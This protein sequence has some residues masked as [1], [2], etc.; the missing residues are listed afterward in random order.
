MTTIHLSRLHAGPGF[1][2]GTAPLVRQVADRLLPIFSRF[3][4]H[5]STGD[6]CHGRPSAEAPWVAEMLSAFGGAIVRFGGPT[7]SQTTALAR[8]APRS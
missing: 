5:A 3:R 4:R 1:I 7:P 6:Q 2:R 8:T